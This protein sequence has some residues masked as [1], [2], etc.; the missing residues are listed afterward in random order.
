ME[1]SRQNRTDTH[2]NSERLWQHAQNLHRFKPDKILS[3]RRGGR[4]K[5]LP[6]NR[7]VFEI[8]TCWGRENHFSSMDCHWAY[9]PHFMEVSMARSSWPKQTPLLMGLFV[10]FSF[11]FIVC[12]SF[13]VFIFNVLERNGEKEG[14]RDRERSCMGRKV[15]RILKELGKGKNDQTQVFRFRHKWLY[16]LRHLTDP[17]H[18]FFYTYIPRVT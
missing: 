5:T 1:S 16:C 13:Q 2:T 3:L 12:L 7:K 8:I 9:Q 11:C 10:C 4:Y 14:W 17:V 15:G 18:L 6:T